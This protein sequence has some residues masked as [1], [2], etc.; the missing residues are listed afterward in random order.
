MKYV[1]LFE[2]FINEKA[3]P[4]DDILKDETQIGLISN[5]RK[6]NNVKSIR[7]VLYDFDDRRVMGYIFMKAL[8]VSGNLFEVENTAAEK[9]YGPD[10]YDLGLM[11]IYPNKMKPDTLIKPE[12]LNLW[13]YYI[14]NRED[15]IKTKLSTDDPEYSTRYEFDLTSD[16]RTDKENLDVINTVFSKEKNDFLNMLLEKGKLYLQKYNLKP[17]TIIE[18]ADKYFTKRYYTPTTA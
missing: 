8:N 13:K 12:A 11:Y 18:E 5:E 14:E 2:S 6:L 9:N 17:Q 1:K 10:I 16:Y 7:L 15:V 3:I 4:F